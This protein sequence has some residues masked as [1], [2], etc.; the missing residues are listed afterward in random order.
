MQPLLSNEVTLVAVP[1][2]RPENE[3][4]GVTQM[5][6]IIAKNAGVEDGTNLLK[7]IKFIDKLA[8]HGR[9]D[10]EVHQSSMQA[11]PTVSG[12]DVRSD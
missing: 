5:V 4:H 8:N 7:R 1:S 3:G 2:H 12:K 10:P 6:K 9:R 11:D